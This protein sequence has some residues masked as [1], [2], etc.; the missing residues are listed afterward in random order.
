MTNHN[1]ANEFPILMLG[2]MEGYSIHENILNYFSQYQLEP[3]IVLECKDIFSILDFVSEEIGIAILPQS[4]VY[5]IFTNRVKTIKIKDL[6]QFVEPSIISLKGTHQS[7]AARYFL[8]MIDVIMLD[9][10]LK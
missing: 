9:K 4:E 8:N 7:R 5:E 3:N 1:E 2:S 10:M 6:A